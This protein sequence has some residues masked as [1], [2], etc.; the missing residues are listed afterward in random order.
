M[1]DLEKAFWVNKALNDASVHP[2]STLEWLYDN[3]INI[4]KVVEL[5]IT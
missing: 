3:K 4:K 5:R 1:K 2:H